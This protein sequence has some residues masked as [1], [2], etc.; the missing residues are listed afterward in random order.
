VEIVVIWLA[1]AIIV[2]IAAN[3]R[4]RFGFGWFLLA[5]LLS[6]LIAGLVV[7]A[8]PRLKR[9]SGEP[10]IEKP[11]TR[12]TEGIGAVFEPDGLYAGLPYRVRTD[13]AIIAIIQGRPCRFENMDRF[14]N[15]VG[16]ATRNDDGGDIKIER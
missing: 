5:C 12:E 14:I 4:G 2:G 7:V 3:T 13:G 10:K 8:L 9:D 15:A 6:P 11:T 16:G 1:F